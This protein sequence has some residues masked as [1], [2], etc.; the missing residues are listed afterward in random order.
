MTPD[1]ATNP[2]HAAEH[3]LAPTASGDRGNTGN[4]GVD[5]MSEA[6]ALLVE[7]RRLQTPTARS[8]AMADDPASVAA[9]ELDR[10]R[11][12]RAW[13]LAKLANRLMERS[14]GTA[15]LQRRLDRLQSLNDRRLE[16]ERRRAE[17]GLYAGERR[18]PNIP[19]HVETS[20]EAWNAIKKDVTGRKWAAL[21]G[22]VGELVAAVADSDSGGLRASVSRGQTTP[23]PSAGRR[24]RKFVRLLGV[25][26][27]Q[28]RR[29]R[30]AAVDMDVTTARLVGIVVEAAAQRLEDI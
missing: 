4:H 16:R 18:S 13:E 25:E 7:A 28:W 8:N 5:L 22:A 21:G 1:Q 23:R 9:H 24:A 2:T 14:T 27:D 11:L 29:F 20:D 10:Q 15:I 6:D 26:P 17:G 3:R 19:T 12:A 30:A